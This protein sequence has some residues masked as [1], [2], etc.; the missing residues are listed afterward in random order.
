MA[1]STPY[2]QLLIRRDI[3]AN[4]PTLGIGEPFFATDTGRLWIGASGGPVVATN[5]YSPA[6]PSNWNSPAPTT[7]VAALDRLAAAVKLL[8]GNP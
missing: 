8:G 6:T 5:V 2:R 4:L 7:I 1:L 3:E